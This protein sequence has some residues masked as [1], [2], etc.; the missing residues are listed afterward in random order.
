MQHTRTRNRGAGSASP[1]R[2]AF[3]LLGTSFLALALLALAHRAPRPEARRVVRP[4]PA[5]ARV[6]DMGRLLVV[7]DVS[8]SMRGGKMVR[9]REA[10]RTVLDLAP[11][12]ASVGLRVFASRT[13]LVSRCEPGGGGALAGKIDR[14][15]VG[16]LRGGDYVRGSTPGSPAARSLGSG[17][18]MAGALE[19]SGA[20]LADAGPLGPDHWVLVSDGMP[21]RPEDVFEAARTLAR[22]YPALRCDTVGIELSPPG[23]AVLEKV[24]TIL[25]GRTWNVDQSQLRETLVEAAS[26][27]SLTAFE[28]SQATSAG[29]TRGTSSTLPAT[30]AWA[31]LVGGLLAAAGLAG[32][33]REAP[34]LVSL[35]VAAGASSWFAA[36]LLLPHHGTDG[37]LYTC[38][39]S[40]AYFM[41]VAV[42][43]GVPLAAQ[44]DLY[45]GNPL[46]ALDQALGAFPRAVL[47]G[48]AAGL[49]GQAVFLASGDAAGAGLLLAMT[50]RTLGWGLAGAVVGATPGAVQQSPRLTADGARGGA[51]GGLAGGALFEAT[52]RIWGSAGLPR[53]VALASLAVAIAWMV[54]AVRELNKAAWF[55]IQK[56]G[57]VGK[58][59]LLSKD[60]TS[61]GSHYQDDVCV[62]AATPGQPRREALVIRHGQS[63]ILEALPG[64][65]ITLNDRK[66]ER[67]PLASGDIVG[68]GA[69]LLRFGAHEVSALD[70]ADPYAVLE[71][72]RPDGTLEPSRPRAAKTPLPEAP[73]VHFVGP[74]R[75]LGADQAPEEWVMDVLPPRRRDDEDPEAIRF[76]DPRNED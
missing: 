21:D 17:T 41:V 39:Q 11:P 7:L 27:G 57:P 46:K 51:L 5:A 38:A 33:S 2:R 1:A 19:A 36:E 25:R 44:E 14:L 20:D 30:L 10:V 26:L 60:V 4:R 24:A 35:C 75:S 58:A 32:A 50:L 34:Y 76:L 43:L 6:Q 28:H 71:R 53:L 12:E 23:A 70:A 59:L 49:L 55:T 65:D 40:A 67:A 69:A 74:I 68:V 18:A 9:A 56:G 54:R 61:L 45:L 22:G 64:V 52:L 29:G 62:R 15:D 31:L 66:V 63:W 47:G 37:V 42:V 72:I 16:G 8:G 73:A 13:A 48:A 3:A